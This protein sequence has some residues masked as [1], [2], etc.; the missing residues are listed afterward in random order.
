MTN[1]IA[2]IFNKV[3]TIEARVIAERIASSVPKPSLCADEVH[4]PDEPP[5]R[6]SPEPFP[7][8][9]S[10]VAQL[11][12]LGHDLL[13]FYQAANRLYNTAVR[14]HAP[15]W[16]LEF[17]DQ[18]KTERVRELG[19]IR[20]YRSSVPM[21]IRPDLLALENGSF[22]ATE[23]DSVP[24]GFGTLASLSHVYNDLEFDIVGGKNGIITGLANTLRSVA[25]D[26]DPSVAIVVSDESE[27]YRAE[28]DWIAT[29]LRDVGLQAH[30]IHPSALRLQDDKLEMTTIDGQRPVNV[31]YRFFELHDLPNIQKID[32]LIYAVKHRLAIITAPFKAHLEEKLLF[33]LFHHPELCDFW[34]TELGDNAWARLC[35]TLPPTWLIDSRPI[36][37]TAA[38]DPEL[39]VG[40]HRIRHWPDLYGL[41]QRRR[42]LVMKPSGFSE[43]SWGSRGVTIGHDV[44]N[45]AWD[46]AVKQALTS[47]GQTPYVIQHYHQSRRVGARYF[48]FETSTI[49]PFEGRAR[50][51]PYYTVQDEK[52]CLSG[53]LVTVVPASSKVIH[54]S[55]M[56]VMM[57]ATTS[58]AATI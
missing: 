47:F 5:W 41:S 45:E 57:P 37:P 24:G 3:S 49:K 48:D 28:M 13:A 4:R 27:D 31:V 56:S 55:P 30:Q 1:H 50:I 15:G 12:Q 11:E 8:S 18:G 29:A 52:A 53:V 35:Q 19:R 43:L 46:A 58:D 14:G 38:I 7:L 20:R 44:T 32:L 2:E 16:V 33:A 22:V 23:L 36:P 39:A 34:H 42:H 10:A 25:G 51:C 21:L 54:G 40:E 26:D 17:L 9:P 6:I